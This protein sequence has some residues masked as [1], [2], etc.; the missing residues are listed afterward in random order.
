MLPDYEIFE[1][2]NFTTIGCVNCTKH[3]NVTITQLAAQILPKFASEIRISQVP[4]KMPS[5]IE[6]MDENI[7]FTENYTISAK[8]GDWEVTIEN[9]R[10]DVEVTNSTEI[11]A[12]CHVWHKHECI[13]WIAP[14][15]INDTEFSY[16]KKFDV[17]S[18]ISKTIRTTFVD[19]CVLSVSAELLN[20]YDSKSYQ[21]E[22]LNADLD[23]M[24]TLVKF[25]QYLNFFG[26]SM[27]E[28][29][30]QQ[31]VEVALIPLIRHPGCFNEAT[32]RG[33]IN[34][35]LQILGE[36]VGQGRSTFFTPNFFARVAGVYIQ[37][38]VVN[39]DHK[40]LR[41]QKVVR[42]VDQ[43]TFVTQ[44]TMLLN[45]LGKTGESS[46]EEKIM[47]TLNYLMLRVNGPSPIYVTNFNQ[48]A[49]TMKFFQLRG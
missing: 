31:S 45:A 15:T 48:T 1:I 30:I 27:N 3:E 35:L 12:T 38:V 9:S 26:N 14:P 16:L 41:A 11:A 23:D 10:T 5:I 13:V 4:Y 33:D 19:E 24:T 21:E 25:A 39:Q 42:T 49:Q 2:Q 28:Y 36:L 8:K 40:L 22:L 17:F 18:K 46:G 20:E 43:H 29:H 7:V 37:R 44:A 47:R 34:F 32:F 6:K